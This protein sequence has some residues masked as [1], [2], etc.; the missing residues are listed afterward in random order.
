MRSRTEVI[1][2]GGHTVTVRGGTV[3]RMGG[4]RSGQYRIECSCGYRRTLAA[5]K[6]EAMS[7]AKDHLPN[8][9]AQ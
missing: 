6:R 3:S 8:P 2:R 4:T 5:T 7:Y 1:E 9:E